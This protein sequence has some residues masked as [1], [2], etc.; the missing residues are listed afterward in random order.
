MFFLL[1]KLTDDGVFDDF[2][3]ISDH[4]PKIPEDFLNYYLQL[5]NSC[6]LY[7]HYNSILTRTLH[8]GYYTVAR[9][10]EFYF[11][12]AKQYFTNE[13]SEWVKYCFCHKKIK[14]ISSSRRVPVMFF[15]LYRHA[16]DGVFDDFPNVSDHLPKISEDFLKLFRIPDERSRTFSENFRKL[17]KMS[18]D[19]R[20]L[21][22]KTRRCFDDTS[23]NLSTI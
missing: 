6:L 9:R 8:R 20:R 13:R 19:C 7:L 11:R 15:L 3:K 23:T 2:P 10:Y 22:R 12:V 4:L 16:D 14:F 1:Y 18:E 17:P 21:P 5:N